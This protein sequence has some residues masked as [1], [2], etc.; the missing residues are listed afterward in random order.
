MNRISA[1]SPFSESYAEARARFI[2]TAR[3][4]GLALTSHVHPDLGHMGETLAM[5]V[6]RLGRPD[7]LRLLIVSSACH[8]VE[9]YCGSGI[10]IAAMQSAQWLGEAAQAGVAVVFIHAINPYGFSHTRRV[11]HE[12]VDLNRNF[13]NFAAPLPDSS[14]YEEVHP[15]LL[16]AHWPPDATCE[17]ALQDFIETRGIKALQAAVTGGQYTV[18]DGLFF[19]GNAPTWSNTTV[20]T[21]LRQHGSQAAHL[22][23]I[24]LHTGLGPCGHGERGYAGKAHDTATRERANRWWGGNGATPLMVLDDGSSVSAPLTGLMWGAVYDECPQAQVTSMAIEFGTQPLLQVLQALR[25]EQWLQMHPNA[26][27]DQAARIK[28][29]LRD[30]FYVDTDD[31]KQK[32]LTQALQAMTQAVVGLEGSR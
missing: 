30:A 29:D 17:A 7:A 18:P 3:H 21:V 25:A 1:I 32:I 4:A 19:G 20:R 14:A 10:Q 8:G 23:W 9:G 31:W 24:D 5:D 2:D 16:P 12:N 22:A 26:P 13:Q 28:R 27:A 11:T 15:L 6:A